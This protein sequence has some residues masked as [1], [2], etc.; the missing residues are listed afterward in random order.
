ME[1]AFDTQVQGTSSGKK[2]SIG[3]RLSNT[4]NYKVVPVSS[5][6]PKAL[7]LKLLPSIYFISES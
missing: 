2:V 7:V 6:V 5:V 4:I 1:T 3:R